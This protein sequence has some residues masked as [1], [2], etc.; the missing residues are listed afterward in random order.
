M[1]LNKF[2]KNINVSFF[3]QTYT[4]RRIDIHN[5]KNTIKRSIENTNN[6]YTQ[7]NKVSISIPEPQAIRIMNKVNPLNDNRQYDNLANS[8]LNT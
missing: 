1:D 3:P 2:P 6:G 8:T 7:N 4:K 5:S